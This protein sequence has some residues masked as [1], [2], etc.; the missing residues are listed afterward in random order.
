MQKK[1]IGIL[2]ITFKEGVGDIRGNPLLSVIDYF[3]DKGYE[4]KIYDKLI[5]ESDVELLNMS[6][7]KEVF[8]F[9]SKKD[10]KKQIGSIASLFSSL[11]DVLNQDIV[12]VS[13]RDNSLK[14]F[15]KKLK[16]NQIIVDLQNLFKPEDFKARYEHL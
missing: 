4:I 6:Y 16:E 7:R 9:I 2:G 8:D 13:N 3:L 12:V 5:D 1:K 15:L 14:E 11:E 10:L